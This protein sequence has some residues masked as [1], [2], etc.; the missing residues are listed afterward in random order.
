M[1]KYIKPAVEF[2]AYV[3]DVLTA[4]DNL[5]SFTEWEDNDIL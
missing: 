5:G 1:K 4:S 2:Y 3:I